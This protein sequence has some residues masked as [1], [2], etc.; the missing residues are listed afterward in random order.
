MSLP[1]LPLSQ[2]AERPTCKVP[3]AAAFLGIS[4]RSMRR[5]LEPGGDLEHL[6]LRVG[7]RVLV[8]VTPLLAVVGS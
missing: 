2:L 8:K 4:E 5:A 1:A 3:E 7:G 6:A